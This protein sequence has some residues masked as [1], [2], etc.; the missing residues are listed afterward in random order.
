MI[1]LPQWLAEIS[2][3]TIFIMLSTLPSHAAPRNDGDTRR[4]FR[5]TVE[6]Y[7]WSHRLVGSHV[8]NMQGQNIGR[9]DAL[10]VNERGALTKVIVALNEQ[11]DVDGT[12][13]PIEPY[14][15]EIVSEKDARITI[16]RVDMTKDEIQRA[17]LSQLQSHAI[18]SNTAPVRREAGAT[19]AQ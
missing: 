12:P 17:Q 7:Y 2:V 14:R 4:A 1:R 6:R 3:V 10:V 9:V 19:V 18:P 5:N 8:L 15:A 11:F 16:I 13:V